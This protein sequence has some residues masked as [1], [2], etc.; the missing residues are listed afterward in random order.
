MLVH[1]D[2][3]YFGE[4]M[5]EDTFRLPKY[6]LWMMRDF[7]SE[8]LEFI[9]FQLGGEMK[10]YTIKYDGDLKKLFPTIERI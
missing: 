2:R 6:Y 8:V 10:Q 1:N 3:K 5:A 7:L 4:K 9:S